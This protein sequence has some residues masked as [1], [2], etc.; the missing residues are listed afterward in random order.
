[1]LARLASSASLASTRRLVVERQAAAFCRTFV[2]SLTP[3]NESIPPPPQ[4]DVSKETAAIDSI[5]NLLSVV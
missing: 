4:L 5:D 2:W 3:K 1:M